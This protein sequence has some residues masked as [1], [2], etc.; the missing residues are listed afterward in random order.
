M[1]DRDESLIYKALHA[2]PGQ[3]KTR[4][5]IGVNFHSEP[6]NK[7]FES[8]GPANR[9]CPRCNGVKRSFSG[10]VKTAEKR[11]GVRK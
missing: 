9:L 6:C 4:I 7:K 3:V 2:K 1:T 10:R 5:C 11:E 8:M